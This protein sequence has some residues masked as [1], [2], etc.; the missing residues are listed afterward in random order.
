ML[1]LKNGKKGITLEVK[2]SGISVR[3]EQDGDRRT[4]GEFVLRKESR[5]VVDSLTTNMRQGVEK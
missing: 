2:V 5:G 4:G 3:R 1:C